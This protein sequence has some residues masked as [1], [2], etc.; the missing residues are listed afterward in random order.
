MEL[1]RQHDGRYE[2]DFD[3]FEAAITNRTRIFVLCNPHNPVGRVF[4]REELEQMAEICLRHDIVICSDEI[5]CDLAFPGYQHI[6]IAS[7]DPE[8]GRKTITLIAP[9]KT[10]NIAGLHCSIAIIENE[11]L[12]EQ[13]E[14]AKGGMVPRLDIMGYTAGLAAYQH[15]QPWLDQVL[16]YLEAN[17]SYLCGYVEDRLP[18][19]SMWR[20]E[21]TYLAWLDCR[22]AGLPGNA[23][24][25]FLSEAK[26]ALNDGATFGK[27]G[28]GFLRLNFG[29]PRPTLKDALER[30]EAALHLL[31]A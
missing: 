27:G 28:E 30:M 3:A 23:H 13:Y 2:V 11:A 7:L 10:F 29:C 14:A 24:D 31:L 22:Q 5:H 18:G 9:S 4:L 1:T 16:A 8:I 21:G 25:F 19:I 6:P 26:V 20:P 15:G 17:L 12:R